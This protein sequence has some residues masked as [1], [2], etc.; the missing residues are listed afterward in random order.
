MLD[1]ANSAPD[2]SAPKNLNFPEPAVLF[3]VAV[4]ETEL[5]VLEGITEFVEAEGETATAWAA[6]VA[7]LE[8]AEGAAVLEVTTGLD[9]PEML[10]AR[11][12][13]TLLDVARAVGIVT[14][15]AS[16]VLL[17][18]EAADDSAAVVLGPLNPQAS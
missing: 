8:A 2:S 3:E 15:V 10:D 14:L 1:G 18:A 7:T 9:G 6:E 16:V 4:P 5:V 12:A 11:T 17:G 13:A